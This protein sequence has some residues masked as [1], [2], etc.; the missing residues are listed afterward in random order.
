MGVQ[1]CCRYCEVVYEERSGGVGP[2]VV[3]NGYIA[4][5][6]YVVQ[7]ENMDA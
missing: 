6:V 3:M 5:P 7:V 1:K 4:V 2:K